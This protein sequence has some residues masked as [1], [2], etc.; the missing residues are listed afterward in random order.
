MVCTHLQHDPTG[1][2]QEMQVAELLGWIDGELGG[3]NV[4][5]GG[6]F[7]ATPGFGASRVME[8]AMGRGR[9]E[10]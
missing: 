9:A 8:M 7:N 10:R 5:I 4:V 3:G 2:E 1:Y 6:D